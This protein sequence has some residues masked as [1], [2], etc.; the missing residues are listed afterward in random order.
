M[1]YGL[2]S[3]TIMWGLLRRNI[4]AL[5]R[6]NDL[7]NAGETIIIPSIVDYEIKRAFCAIPSPEKELA[8][9]RLKADCTILELNSAMLEPAAQFWAKS[10]KRGRTLGETDILVAFMCLHYDYIL[11]TRYTDHFE[12]IP[13]LKLES[14]LESQ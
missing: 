4:H 12:N 10:F 8:Y 7:K 6:L 14:W 13:G 5:K 1:A 2:D 9:D 3:E 11:V